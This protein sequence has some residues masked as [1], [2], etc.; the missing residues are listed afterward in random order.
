MLKLKVYL[1]KKTLGYLIICGAKRPSG[2]NPDGW[3]TESQR[4]RGAMCGQLEEA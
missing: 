4:R 2:E 1:K 3:M